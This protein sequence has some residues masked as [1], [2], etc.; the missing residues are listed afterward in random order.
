MK[1]LQYPLYQNVRPLPDDVK[2]DK[3]SSFKTETFKAEKS[4][5]TL[6]IHNHHDII[7]KTTDSMRSTT[8]DG[9]SASA[10][11][12]GTEGCVVGASSSSLSEGAVGAVGSSSSSSSSGAAGGLSGSATSAVTAFADSVSGL[13]GSKN[14]NSDNLF[15]LEKINN[16][17]YRPSE[18]TDFGALE[19]TIAKNKAEMEAAIA[20]HKEENL[21]S[22]EENRNL[23]STVSTSVT[24]QSQHEQDRD[25]ASNKLLSESAKLLNRAHLRSSS[26]KKRAST[27]GRPSAQSRSPS[28]T[29]KKRKSSLGKPPLGSSFATFACTSQDKKNIPVLSPSNRLLKQTSSSSLKS[30]AKK[31]K[32][33]KGLLLGPARRESSIRRIES[34][35][36]KRRS[37]AAARKSSVTA[38]A[39]EHSASGRDSMRDKSASSK[40]LKKTATAA[41]ASIRNSSLILSRQ[42][43]FKTD[44]GVAQQSG[45]AAQNLNRQINPSAYPFDP[46]ARLSASPSG[47]VSSLKSS[48]QKILRELKQGMLEEKYGRRNMFSAE[49]NQNAAVQNAE[50]ASAS[51]TEKKVHEKST[52]M[53]KSSLRS[54][55]SSPSLKKS[56]KSRSPSS[57][58]STSSSKRSKK[59]S[60]RGISSSSSPPPEGVCRHRDHRPVSATSNRSGGHAT[61]HFHALLAKI[62]KIRT[63]PGVF[64][65]GRNAVRECKKE[66]LQKTKPF[67]Q[68]IKGIKGIIKVR[69]IFQV[70]GQISEY[71]NT[72][73]EEKIRHKEVFFE[74]RRKRSR[75][76][77]GKNRSAKA[78][79]SPHPTK[80]PDFEGRGELRHGNSSQKRIGDQSRAA[81]RARTK[82]ARSEE[83]LSGTFFPASPGGGWNVQWGNY[84]AQWGWSWCGRGR[85]FCCAFVGAVGAVGEGIS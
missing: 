57:R 54:R 59:K 32:A 31:E 71:I 78:A 9:S 66:V 12:T 11:T 74:N 30:S 14:S 63:V 1:D 51:D 65:W 5:R 19:K 46:S 7:M 48:T 35:P 21:S 20:R 27:L 53:R 81:A 10:V 2:A 40:I 42:E 18:E 45:S 22:T 4:P 68:W 50:N 52:E 70:E 73:E 58:R 61:Q 47:I 29:R 62:P 75:R 15:L 67:L 8:V 34:S 43:A 37:S 28:S 55:K 44:V 13:S 36:Y 69:S 33:E 64:Q 60:K 84:Y 6:H 82:T 17:S 3:S 56:R 23:S 49:E 26:L 76:K 38:A 83:P 25:K 41:G 85:E 24:Q 77:N 72:Q 39:R 79:V 16:G 80:Q